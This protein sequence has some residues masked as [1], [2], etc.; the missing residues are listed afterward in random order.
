L[1]YQDDQSGENFANAVVSLKSKM[2]VGNFEMDTS[3]Y[4]LRIEMETLCMAVES[5]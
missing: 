5:D 3:S 2:V 1:H 4:Y